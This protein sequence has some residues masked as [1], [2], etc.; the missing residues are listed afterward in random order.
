MRTKR[1]DLVARV[2]SLPDDLLDDVQQSLD[3]IVRWHQAGV[4]C[5]SDD[6]RAGVRKGMDAAERGEFVSDEE[7]AAFRERHRGG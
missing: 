6:E 3:D 2:A 7:M 4:Y 5:L 1:Q